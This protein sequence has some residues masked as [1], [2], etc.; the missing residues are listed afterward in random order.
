VEIARPQV[1]AVLAMMWDEA[2]PV[3]REELAELLWGEWDLPDH[4]PGAVRGVV[5]KVRRVLETAG[6]S[7]DAVVSQAGLTRLDLPSGATTDLAEAE[8]LVGRVG[9]ELRDGD[10]DTAMALVEQALVVL[11]R[12]LAI[13]AEGDWPR[14]LHLRAETYQR[15]A[16]RLQVR[17]LLATGRNTEAV[18]AA[19]ELVAR[20]RL[21]EVAHELLISANLAAGRRVAARQAHTEL[22][23][24]LESELGAEPSPHI[25]GLVARARTPEPR[26][27]PPSPTGVG[28][29]FLGRHAELAALGEFHDRVVATNAPALLVVQGPTGIGKS[30]LVEEFLAQVPGRA[31]WGRCRA[32][33]GES[34]EPFVD[35][36]RSLGALDTESDRTRS[37]VTEALETLVAHG[38]SSTAHGTRE[39]RARAIQ[40]VVDAVT[41]LCAA[42][43]LVMVIDDLQWASGDSIALAQ[44][45]LETPNLPLFVIA[46][47]RDGVDEPAPMTELLRA[48]PTRVVVLPALGVDDIEPMAVDLVDLVGSTIDPQVLSSLLWQRTGG[49]PYYLTEVV[50]DAGRRRNLQVDTIPEQVRAWVQNRVAS[51]PGDQ[52]SLIETAAVIG[53]RPSVSLVEA[54]WIGPEDAALTGLEQLVRAGFL[55]ETDHPDVLEFPHQITREV[56]EA[57]M[58]AARRTRLHER[59]AEVL[60][61][62]DDGD[63]VHAQ[64]AYHLSQAGPTYVAEAARHAYLA[65]VASLTRGAWAEADELFG[66]ALDL[67]EVAPVPLTASVLVASGWTRHALGDAADGAR[68]LDEA[69]ALAAELHLPHEAA[70][71]ALF[72]TGRAGRGAALAMGDDERVRRLRVALDAVTSWSGHTTDHDT[73]LFPLTDRAQAA[74]RTAVEVE[75]AWAMLFTGSLAERTDLLT[76]TLARARADGATPARLA[77]A[78]LAQRN[79]LTG[80]GQIGERLAVVDEVLALPHDELPV[81]TLVSALLCQH[82]DR[83]SSADR[84]GAHAA[85]EAAT[86]AVQRHA[87]PYWHWAC[88]TWGSLWSLVNGRPDEAEAALCEAAAIQPEGSAEAAACGAVQLVAIR[89]AQGRADEMVDALVASAAAHPEVPAYRAVL[90][91]T[92]SLAGDEA[93]AEKAYR[94]FAAEGFA[95]VPTDSNRLL[96]LAVLGDVAA[97]R[98]DEQGAST[99]DGLLAPDDGV[100]VVLNCYGGGGSWWG[101]VARIRSRLADVL[102]RPDDAEAARARAQVSIDALGAATLGQPGL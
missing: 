57:Q 94:H 32:V 79:V 78:L 61:G 5:A 85:L 100:M 102:G 64:V 92:A 80:P 66:S 7:A 21:D 70:R 4:W 86:R 55:I 63:R 38:P 1:A 76:G 14:R 33:L 26:P 67:L 68:L 35:A 36:F 83:L 52:G 42:A 11:D 34:F 58:S 25:A 75:L 19:S 12:P 69:T 53:L 39:R 81:D 24:V 91:L 44:R 45:L 47:A 23:E 73:A 90:A 17:A 31:L 93:T 59:V 72:L 3:R 30:R 84:E 97:D 15:Q 8:D 96:T 51:L 37:M 48:A 2:R 60:V 43:P 62:A 74:L 54:C 87:H 95:G 71:S 89:L 101:P 28:E 77:R 65:G 40:Q 10:P 6:F 41:E 49:L 29:R 18:A 9:D 50:R 88:A 46:T 27:D 13:V 56:V 22:I 98:G 16:R 99:L 20:D 82:E